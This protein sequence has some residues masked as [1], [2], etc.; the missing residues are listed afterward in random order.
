MSVDPVAVSFSLTRSSGSAGAVLQAPTFLIHL[1][2]EEHGDLADAFA[3]PDGQRFTPE[4][5][6]QELE[7]GEPHFP[8]A[9]VALRARMHSSLQVGG[10]R[11]IAAE[12]IEILHGP[13]SQHL[14]Y[15]DRTYLNL[16]RILELGQPNP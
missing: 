3:R 10:S 11:L 7:N 15:Q 2:G 9:P 5:N 4:Q 8:L 12:V 14:L 13:P 6:W 1:L 16:S